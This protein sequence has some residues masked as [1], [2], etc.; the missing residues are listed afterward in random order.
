MDNDGG[1]YGGGGG[2]SQGVGVGRLCVG[3]GKRLERRGRIL[4]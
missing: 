3:G 4:M 1:G 2:R